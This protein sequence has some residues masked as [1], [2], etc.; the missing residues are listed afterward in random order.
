LTLRAPV[1]VLI[2]VHNGE[3]YLAEAVESVLGQTL[4]PVELLVIDDGSTDSTPEVCAAFGAR[5]RYLRRPHEGVAASINAGILETREDLLS[6]L[7]A[8][9]LWPASKLEQQLLAINSSADTDMVFGRMEQFRSPE[10]PEVFASVRHPLL[11]GYSRGAMLIRRSAFARTGGFDARWRV[12][13]FVDWYLRARDLGLREVMLP[14]LVLRRRLHANNM[15]LRDAAT[16]IDFARIVRAALDRRQ[17]S[18]G[19]SSTETPARS[20]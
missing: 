2:A 11:D 7:D 13:E 9:D 5:L 16:R 4:P 18:A 14:D 8:D 3:K 17:P 12:G 15:G 6:F 10:L 1:S 19:L 20:T